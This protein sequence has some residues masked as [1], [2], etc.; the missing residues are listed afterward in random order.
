MGYSNTKNDIRDLL[1]VLTDIDLTWRIHSTEAFTL[2]YLYSY[3]KKEDR[4]L[5]VFAEI[6]ALESIT[7][8]SRVVD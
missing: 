5:R 6:L 7:S 4:D 2:S 3:V 1:Y 8:E